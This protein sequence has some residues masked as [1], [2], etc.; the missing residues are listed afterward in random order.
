MTE[1]ITK[2]INYLNKINKIIINNTT[3]KEKLREYVIS[4]LEKLNNSCYTAELIRVQRLKTISD[5]EALE[6]A[7]VGGECTEP[8][9]EGKNTGGKENQVYLRHIQ[10]KEL[11]EKI[12]GMTNEIILLDD[13]LVDNK[14]IVSDALGELLPA[15]KSFILRLFYIECWSKPKIAQK[16]NYSFSAVKSTKRRAI[17]DL[18]ENLF[19]QLKK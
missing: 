13:S 7:Y 10:I 8:R 12:A 15:D 18:T 6:K 1:T 11:K 4:S 5:L 14:K 17:N 2:Y 3:T 19:K 16:Y 9:E